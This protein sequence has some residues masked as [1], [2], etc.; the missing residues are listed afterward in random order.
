MAD[1]F[2]NL[3]RRPRP[4]VEQVMASLEGTCRKYDSAITRVLWV[5]GA[6]MVWMIIAESLLSVTEIQ[7]NGT[8]VLEP[9]LP[10]DFPLPRAKARVMHR[11]IRTMKSECDQDDM[12]DGVVLA[13]QVHV[14][15]QPYMHRIMVLCDDS[16]ELI[17]P[18]IAVRGSDSGQCQ[19]EHDG[20]TKT[21]I[22]NYPITVHSAGAA[23][24]T[25]LHLEDVCTFMHALSLLD[26][27]W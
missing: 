11:V 15:G 21:S 17:N 27:Q 20:T 4:H 6:A 24:H 3:R 19:D 8:W 7:F 12:R 14:D 16:I 5:V 1:V 23:P 25:L 18:T 10:V 9:T 22:R 26:S 13:P 2:N